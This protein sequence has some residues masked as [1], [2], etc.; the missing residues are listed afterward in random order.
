[1][2]HALLPDSIEQKL[3]V[4]AATAAVSEKSRVC[5]QSEAAGRQRAIERT[6]AQAQPLGTRALSSSFL[7]ACSLKSREC[8]T[9]VC[10]LCSL[11]AGGR[12]GGRL[13]REVAMVVLVA[14]L[15]HNATTN[16]SEHWRAFPLAL[17]RC[18]PSELFRLLLLRG[19][20]TVAGFVL[21]SFWLTTNK[22]GYKSNKNNVVVMVVLVPVLVSAG[23]Q[24]RAAAVAKCSVGLLLQLFSLL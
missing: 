20:R 10:S 17:V 14:L 13:L 7:V 12:A 3:S 8:P 15:V 9:K 5:H 24:N 23:P 1:M 22:K 16:A 18:A 6:N 21:Q 19:S 4:A 2:L 11:Q